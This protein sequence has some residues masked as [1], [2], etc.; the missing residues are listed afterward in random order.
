[1]SNRTD[2]QDGIDFQ[3]NKQGVPDSISPTNQAE[4]TFQPI[5][6]GAVM[7]DELPYTV[8]P[9]LV[10][11]PA[12]LYQYWRRYQNERFGSVNRL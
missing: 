10:T 11:S 1:M 2:A 5:L 8:T 3:K 4:K 6:D 12:K 9:E 7:G